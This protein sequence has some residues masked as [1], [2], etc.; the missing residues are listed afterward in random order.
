MTIQAKRDRLHRAQIGHYLES[1]KYTKYHYYLGVPLMVL[2]GVTNVGVLYQ[3]DFT[4]IDILM[5]GLII[6]T[7]LVTILSALQTFLNFYQKAELHRSMAV[8][9]GKIK[10]DIE[11]LLE[12]DISKNKVD[13]YLQSIQN[14]WNNV[15]EMA[16]ITPSSV[17]AKVKEILNE[18]KK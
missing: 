7:L 2:S 10:R 16:P 9:Y 18:D 5:V 17:R 11:M 8:K 6:S 12:R 1:E 4:K 3:V 15:A 13:E 14:E